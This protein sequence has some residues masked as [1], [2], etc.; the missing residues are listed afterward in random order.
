MVKIFQNTDLSNRKENVETTRLDQSIGKLISN[1]P[2]SLGKSDQTLMVINSNQHKLSSKINK[3]ISPLK[4]QKVLNTVPTTSPHIMFLISIKLKLMH[5]TSNHLMQIT[6]C[7]RD[8][9]TLI[10]Q[11]IQSQLLSNLLNKEALPLT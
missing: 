10:L 2:P 9:K 11:D 5:R 7:P 4:F 6:L 1:P 8:L 3:T